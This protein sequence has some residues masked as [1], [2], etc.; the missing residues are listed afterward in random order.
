MPYSADVSLAV[1]QY[2]QQH[3][4]MR[5]P[6]LFMDSL[7]LFSLRSRNPSWI[8]I[9]YIQYA[10]HRNNFMSPPKLAMSMRCQIPLQHLALISP[11]GNINGDTH[12]S[13][14]NHQT[15]KTHGD[16]KVYFLQRQTRLSLNYGKHNPSHIQRYA[17][18]SQL[19]HNF[20]SSL[21]FFPFPRG[22]QH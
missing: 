3:G 15:H 20:I 2:Q 22:L 21:Y 5:E 19:S 18:L 17:L 4:H 11:L 14:Q 8:W 1:L 10:T 7:H 12:A 16:S 6:I 13:P 9:R